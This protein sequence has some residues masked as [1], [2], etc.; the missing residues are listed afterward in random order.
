MKISENWLRQWVNPAVDSDVLA[1]QL[2]MAGLEVDDSSTVA[3]PFNGVVVGEVLTVEQHPDADRLRVTTVSIGAIEPLQI[4]CGAPNVA[5]GLKV[6]VATVGA[7]LPGGGSGQELKIKK[8]KLRGV[9]SHGMLCG[10]SEID[11]ED[12]IDGLLILPPDA[13]IGMDIRDYL[14]LDDRVIE[15]SI[16]PNRGDCFSIKGIARELGVINQLSVTPVDIQPVVATI[17]TKKQIV[18]NSKG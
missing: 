2:T 16:T 1:H 12:T 15:I 10:A 14:Q 7:I 9:E 17:D 8:G 13:P 18:L 6:P 11:L 5:V 4:V 3:K